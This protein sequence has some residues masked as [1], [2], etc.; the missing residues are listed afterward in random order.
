M[1][2]SASQSEVNIAPFCAYFQAAL[3][4][5]ETDYTWSIPQSFE[6][7]G[8]RGR[9]YE[10]NKQLKYHFSRLWHET[11]REGREELARKIVSDWG[12]VRANRPET[13]V[14][15]IDWIEHER[16]VWP[17]QGVASYSKI[18]SIVA[19]D[20]FAIYDARVAVSLIAIQYIFGSSRGVLFHYVPGRNKTT[21]DNKGRGFTNHP[22]FKSRALK[23]VGW[24]RLR[25]NANYQTYLDTLNR[26]A[27]QLWQQTQFQ[28][29]LLC[30][31]EMSLFANAERLA[32]RA[33][34]LA[35]QD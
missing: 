27:N 9:G 4:Q 25:P 18:L 15:Y 13:L 19:P 32:L 10:A 17:K 20:K 30:D 7:Y 35:E 14:R 33:M 16:S 6:E 2:T 3:P 12:G 22:R 21:G 23:H 8:F 29:L 11:D 26:V 24:T 31:L 1:P 5:L 28:D 34:N